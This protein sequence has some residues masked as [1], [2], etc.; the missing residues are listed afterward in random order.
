[1]T[2]LLPLMD[3][4]S[5]SGQSC[6][7]AAQAPF[8]YSGRFINFTEII[9]KKHTDTHTWKIFLKTIGPSEF[10]WC[11][12]WTYKCV[13]LD[14]AFVSSESSDHKKIVPDMLTPLS[15]P[16]LLFRS[17]VHKPRYV[18]PFLFKIMYFYLW[19]L[20]FCS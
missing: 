1:M 5:V 10:M 11:R 18:N 8:L 12:A 17:D 16:V 19:T 6:P 3:I 13:F 4:L 7:S 14:V 2:E 15:I 9:S 20:L